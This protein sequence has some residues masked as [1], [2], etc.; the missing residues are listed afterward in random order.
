MTIPSADQAIIA[1]EKLSAYLL[2]PS[3]RRGAAKARLLTSLG[4]R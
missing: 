1:V 4:Y 2:N 3:H